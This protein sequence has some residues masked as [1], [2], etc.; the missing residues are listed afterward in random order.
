MKSLAIILFDPQ[1]VKVGVRT[2]QSQFG[3]QQV[4]LAGA[5]WIFHF[6]WLRLL[7]CVSGVAYESKVFQKHIFHNLDLIIINIYHY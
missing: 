1:H 7:G 6:P 4:P 5:P 3:P 2:P